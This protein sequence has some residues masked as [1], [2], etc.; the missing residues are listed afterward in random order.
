VRSVPRV[1]SSRIEGEAVVIVTEE[2]ETTDRGAGVGSRA[3]F[4]NA[5]AYTCVLA[6][7]RALPRCR[8]F[9]IS[10]DG[11][12]ADPGDDASVFGG[13]KL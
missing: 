5:A 1:A 13:L 8:G 7:A 2:L 12:R 4:T 10:L 6:I 9:A 3:H 11:T